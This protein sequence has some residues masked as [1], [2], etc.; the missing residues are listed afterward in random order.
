MMQFVGGGL[1]AGL[2][3][4]GV[5]WWLWPASDGPRLRNVQGTVVVQDTSGKAV[6]SDGPIPAGGTISTYGL[7]S[8]VLIAL[9][10]WF[11]NHPDRRFIG[12]GW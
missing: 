10:G 12:Q 9:S 6:S 1:A 7:G 11:G 2:G 5:G 4:A 8:S 3:G